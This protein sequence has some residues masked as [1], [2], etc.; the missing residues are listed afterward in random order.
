MVDLLMGS[1][2]LEKSS[3]VIQVTLTASMIIAIS[4]D[5]VLRRSTMKAGVQHGAL[6]QM[7]VG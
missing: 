7:E 2:G 4:R 1:V 6:G 3:M 5:L